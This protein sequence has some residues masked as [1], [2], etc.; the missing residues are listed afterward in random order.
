MP[1]GHTKIPGIIDTRAWN[2]HTLGGRCF[3]KEGDVEIPEGMIDY[4]VGKRCSTAAI[5]TSYVWSS[6]YGT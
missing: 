6:V 5:I 3:D 2:W 4:R 1:E